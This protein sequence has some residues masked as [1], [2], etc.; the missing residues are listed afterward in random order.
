[1]PQI[2]YKRWEL[3]LDVR[4]GETVAEANS[5]RHCQNAYITTGKVPKKRPALIRVVDLDPNTKGLSALDGKLHVFHDAQHTPA[6]IPEVENVALESRAGTPDIT[7]IWYAEHF[8]AQF[9]VAAEYDDQATRHHYVNGP[10]TIITDAACPHSRIVTKRGSRLFAKD[11]DVVRYCAGA[12]PTTWTPA[13]LAE[14][15]SAGLLPVNIQADG[16]DIV[17]SL[18]AYADLICVFTDD[19]AQLWHVDADQTTNQFRKL[20]YTGARDNYGVAG[21]AGDLFFRSPQGIRSLTRQAATDNVYDIDVGTRID[22]MIVREFGEG[23]AAYIRKYG[24]FWIWF[25]HDY[26]DFMG[27]AVQGTKVYVYTYSKTSKLSAWST[28]LFPTRIDYITEAYQSV[29]MRGDDALYRLADESESIYKDFGVP[30]TDDGEHI[31]VEL[32]MPF[33]DFQKPGSL[34]MVTGADFVFQGTAEFSLRYDSR[35]PE[36]QLQWQSISGDSRPGDLVPVEICCT[37]LA[38][39][40]RH[41]AN[42]PFQ[43]D[44]IVFHYQELGAI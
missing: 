23:R 42:E 12:D 5:L 43:L 18:G 39:L 22:P 17:K 11:K 27:K 25:D 14:A 41:R 4:E 13:D 35:A 2:T 19:H 31:E 3:G 10:T 30:G 6:V 40:V 28:Y 33:V 34:K 38:P 8:N 44:A 32:E 26:T 24:Q 21:M 36:Y 15:T 1:M 20:I 9:Y 7:R 29:W 16:N 37:S